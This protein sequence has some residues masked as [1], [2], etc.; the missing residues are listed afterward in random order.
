MGAVPQKPS[1]RNIISSA[2]EY[3]TM[4]EGCPPYGQQP[5]VAQNAV[6]LKDAINA[7]NTG[8]DGGMGRGMGQMTFEDTHSKNI[9]G[10]LMT[11][12]VEIRKASQNEG[13]KNFVVDGGGSEWN[14]VNPLK[15]A[16]M[17]DDL[18]KAEATGMGRAHSTYHG[19]G[20]MKYKSE[21]NGGKLQVRDPIK[22]TLSNPPVK[23]ATPVVNKPVVSAMSPGG[24]RR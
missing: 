6:Q 9:M 7:Y 4:V 10:A 24:M 1:I 14:R 20:S 18:I 17:L 12:R 11:A 22:G 21:G 3:L 8:I 2:Q 19:Q 16:N 13:L 23:P 5:V 15:L